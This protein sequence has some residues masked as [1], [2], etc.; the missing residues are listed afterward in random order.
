MRKT[1]TA[2][3]VFCCKDDT[4]LHAFNYASHAVATTRLSKLIVMYT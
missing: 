1:N 3:D 2:A 4:F